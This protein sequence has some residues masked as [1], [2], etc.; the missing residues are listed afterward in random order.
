MPPADTFGRG[1]SHEEHVCFLLTRLVERPVPRP[2]GHWSTRQSDRQPV[3][4]V[5]VSAVMVDV[6]PEP[7]DSPVLAG[8]DRNTNSTP[9]FARQV[10]LEDDLSMEEEVVADFNFRNSVVG[11]LV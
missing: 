11:V 4:A 10:A 2:A 9:P 3:E 5:K 6:T 1:G 7:V 8:A